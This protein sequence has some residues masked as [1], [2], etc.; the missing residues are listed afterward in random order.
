MES[1]M[2]RSQGGRPVTT[3]EI[4]ECTT[5]MAMFRDTNGTRICPRGHE[6]NWANDEDEY[7]N[8][9]LRKVTI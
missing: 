9:Y 4:V 6:N 2:D 7:G 8:D 5:C 1:Q 3:A